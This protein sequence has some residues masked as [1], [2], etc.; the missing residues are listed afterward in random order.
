MDWRV[1]HERGTRMA[2]S[3][4][5]AATDDQWQYAKSTYRYLRLSIV[6]VVATLGV[7]LVLQWRK[8]HCLQGSVSAFYY[9]P[10]HSV[11][12]A[13][14]GLIGLALV[15][16]RGATWL[17][18]TLLNIAGF[19]APV[20]A[21]VPT[22]RPSLTGLRCA[23]DPAIGTIPSA[24]SD[25]NL[26]A[27]IIGG[28]G[29]LL[30]VLGPVVFKHKDPKG[31]KSWVRKETV[32]PVLGA[33]FVLVGLFVWR[34]KWPASFKV[35]A[36]SYSAILMFA[37]AGIFVIATARSARGILRV[38]YYACATLMGVGFVVGIVFRHGYYVV[39]VV[40]IIESVAFVTFWIIQSIE[41]WDKGIDIIE[42]APPS[43][44]ALP[45]TN[46]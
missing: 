39:L 35:H 11:F 3:D 41:L 2:Q 31:A 45:A 34:K 24:F 42:P 40:E 19:L 6:V 17:R 9:T 33:A 28:V 38:A 14:L 22:G 15:A 18:E 1:S 13:A 37:L 12:I 46:G 5:A 36:H 26:R 16:I 20:V 21:F 30:L 25:N 29:A 10:V 8:E 43:P 44:P 32:G 7:S 27:F 4:A 23:I